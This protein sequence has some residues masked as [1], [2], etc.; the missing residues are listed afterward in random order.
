MR[1]AASSHHK[2]LIVNHKSVFL[3]LASSF[4]LHHPSLAAPLRLDGPEVAKVTWDSRGLAPADF[5][6][7]GKLDLAL[8]NNENAKFVLLYQRNPGAAAANARRAVSRNRWEPLVE[9]SRFQA[10]SLPTDQRH[11]AL[12]AADFDGDGRPDLA[13]TGASD[14]LL[15]RFQGK[16][17][18]FTKSFSYKNFEPLPGTTSMIA[19]DLDGDG[20]TDLAILA[21]GRLLIFLQQKAG[22][23]TDPVSY[24]TTDDK[25]GYLMAEDVNGDKKPDLVY[26]AA[27]GDGSLR[28]RFQLAP[29]AFSAELALPY[30]QPAEGLYPSRDKAGNLLLT[31]VNPK[32]HLIERHQW[33]TEPVSA[34]PD[35]LLPVVHSAPGGKGGAASALG[36]FDGDGLLDLALADAK[37]AQISLFLQQPDGSYG[38]PQTFPS[39]AGVTGLAPLR[40]GDKRATLAV[41]SAKEGLGLARLGDDGRLSFPTP[42]ACPGTPSLIASADVDGDGKDELLVLGENEKNWQLHTLSTNAATPAVSLTLKAVKREP[43]G[44]KVGDLNGDGR[45]DVVVLLPRDPALLLLNGEKGFGEPVKETAL[46]K[47]QLSDL[48]PER[49]S[50]LDL[51]GDKHAEILVA[52]TGYAR[53]LRLNDAGTDLTIADQ[54]NARQPDDRLIA[55]AFTDLDGDKVPELFF[56]EAGGA[57]FQILKKDAQGVYRF[58]RRLE[59]APLD[60]TEILP[61]SLGKKA[62]PHLLVLGR[63]RFWNISLG[64]NRPALIPAGTHETD[65]QHCTYY[66]AV[67][68]DL[69]NDGVEDIATFDAESK[70]LEVLTPAASPAPWDSLLNFVLFEDN[71]HFRGRKGAN[72]VREV[73]IRDF[74]GDGKADLL[75]LV[76]D[77]VLL[78]P[79]SK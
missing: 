52:G 4:L 10:V 61:L 11:F 26:F 43:A 13:A 8:L 5:D 47:S 54:Y 41:L 72:N 64:G 3:C 1:H 73:L 70:L 48:S 34:H 45:A 78:Y 44:L 14:A 18:S 63:D 6:G 36:D 51:D 15:V 55:P 28:C 66:T 76:H 24:T 71:I 12:A 35:I 23:F 65:L 68:G 2:S 42:L 33:T 38:E 29:G 60:L 58:S 17:A 62:A 69:N 74:T 79:Q 27:S 31:K 49:V 30:T 32:S 53:A 50:L 67:P 40:T 56:A 59:A 21:K 57:F 9:D 19:S 25:V 37:A 39:F 46:L 77:R 20:R 16:D 22:G 7:D 75:L